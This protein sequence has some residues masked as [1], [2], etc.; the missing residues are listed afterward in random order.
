MAQHTTPET[1]GSRRPFKY[2]GNQGELTMIAPVKPGGAEKVRALSERLEEAE[3]GADVLL[4]TLHN[5]RVVFFDN[6]TRMLFATVYDGDW[7]QYIDDFA[8]VKTQGIG[9]LDEVWGVLEGYPGLD[10]PKIKDFL[11]QCQV[12]P[13]YFWS[14]YSDTTVKRSRRAERALAGFEQMLDA[15]G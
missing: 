8:T 10:S 2:S 7:D 1:S 3:A 12:E 14:A 4:A 11:V 5:I 6:D 13:D 15:A 9:L